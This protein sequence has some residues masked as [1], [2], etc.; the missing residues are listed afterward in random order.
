MDVTNRVDKNNDTF[1]DSSF[2][3]RIYLFLFPLH[4]DLQ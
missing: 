1:G 2:L 4:R 3:Q